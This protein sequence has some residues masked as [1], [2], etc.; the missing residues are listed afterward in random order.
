MRPRVVPCD[1][2]TMSWRTSSRVGRVPSGVDEGVRTA[3]SAARQRT[4]AIQSEV[5]GVVFRR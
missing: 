3:A 1:G 4:V 5:I 2:R